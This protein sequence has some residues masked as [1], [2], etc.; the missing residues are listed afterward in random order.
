MVIDRWYTSVYKNVLYK[1]LILFK[2]LLKHSLDP[3][4]FK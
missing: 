2:N 4:E 3:N 1:N